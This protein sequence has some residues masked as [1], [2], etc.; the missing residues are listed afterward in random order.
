MQTPHTEE[1]NR[2]FKIQFRK[3]R[4]RQII[5]TVP[6]IV[7]FFGIEWLRNRNNPISTGNLP[8]RVIVTAFL[9]LAGGRLRSRSRTGDALL[10][11]HTSVVP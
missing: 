9:V 2:E 6:L 5:L 11:T 7:G 8:L 1:Q 4:V 10:A 3:R